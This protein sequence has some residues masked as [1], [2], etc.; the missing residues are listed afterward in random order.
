[1]KSRMTYKTNTGLSPEQ[2]WRFVQQEVTS[3]NVKR[4]GI[5]IGPWVAGGKGRGRDEGRLCSSECEYNSL[6]HFLQLPIFL[7]F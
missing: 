3:V 5:G 1:M 7:P 6:E 4:I 2:A